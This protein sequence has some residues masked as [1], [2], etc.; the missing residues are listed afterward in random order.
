MNAAPDDDRNMALAEAVADITEYITSRLAVYADVTGN[1][2]DFYLIAIDGDMAESAV[3][4]QDA[5]MMCDAFAEQVER[6]V[7]AG[8]IAI[9]D[10][11]DEPLFT[12]TFDPAKVRPS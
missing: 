8:L 4:A 5:D 11:D 6:W 1:K 7:N 9:T 10:S 3:D 2:P 12:A